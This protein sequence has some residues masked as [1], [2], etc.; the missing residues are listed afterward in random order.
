MVLEKIQ[1]QL[2]LGCLQLLSFMALLL[3][4]GRD[5]VCVCSVN[6]CIYIYIH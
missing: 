6:I 2:K 4:T 3:T 5:I 1:W